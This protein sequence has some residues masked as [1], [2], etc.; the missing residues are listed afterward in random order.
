MKRILL[1]VAVS[2]LMAL[3]A[4]ARIAMATGGCTAKGS[5]PRTS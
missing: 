2:A 1:L 3:S 5:A 4:S